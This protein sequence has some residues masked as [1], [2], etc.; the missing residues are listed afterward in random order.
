MNKKKLKKNI[1]SDTKSVF[2]RKVNFAIKRISDIT[3][4]GIG[5]F[6][7]SP[8][9]LVSA[10]LIKITMPGP[11][12]FLQERVGKNGKLFK[13]YKFRTMKIN[14]IAEKAH[15]ASGDATRI[16]KLGRILRRF[17][18]DELPQIINVFIGDMSLV[19][20]R[21]TFPEHLKLYTS[22][23]RQ[24][25]DMRPGMTGLAQVNGNAAL[26]WEDRIEYDLIYIDGFSVG[27]DIKILFRTV[28][29]VLEGEDKFIHKLSGSDES[30]FIY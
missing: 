9:L 28:R 2:G 15:N 24:R 17:K 27:M 13:I 22:H 5:L 1:L 10:V 11:V 8:I 30:K 29:V 14:K 26:R 18:I 25:L 21:P 4:S 19:G 16:T 23:E 12:F 6:I 20:P 7:V 3:L